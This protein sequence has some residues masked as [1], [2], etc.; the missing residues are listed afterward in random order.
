MRTSCRARSS[1]TEVNKHLLE[2]SRRSQAPAYS[3]AGFGHAQLRLINLVKH[4]HIHD[5]AGI[6]CV[7]T[8]TAWGVQALDLVHPHM[9]WPGLNRTQDEHG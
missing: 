5:P 1:Y 2:V 4:D 3:D 9:R 8:A 7:V 6:P